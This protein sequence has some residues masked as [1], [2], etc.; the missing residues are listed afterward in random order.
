MSVPRL[1]LVVIRSTD[2][3]RAE[4]FYGILGLTFCRHSPG[5]GPEHLAYDGP[6]G[7]F[8][9]YPQVAGESPTVATRIGF[10]VADLDEV[11]ASVV[12]AGGTIHRQPSN[13][14]W[15]RRAVIR[16]FDDHLVE[17]TQA[18]N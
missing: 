12:S 5:K 11:I 7:V 14:P 1:N 17:V 8:E 2:L 13:S 3:D 4:R 18:D 6:T 16:D 10:E 9:I 15:G